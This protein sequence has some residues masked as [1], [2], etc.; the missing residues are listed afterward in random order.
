MIIQKDE[1]EKRKIEEE[2]QHIRKE[3]S[4]NLEQWKRNSESAKITD[5]FD[6]GHADDEGDEEELLNEKKVNDAEVKSKPNRNER[7]MR[8]ISSK[9]GRYIIS[10]T[11]TKVINCTTG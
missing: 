5:I 9:K 7:N 4:E 8:Q 11:F 6:D 3:A 2:K 1:E 10:Q